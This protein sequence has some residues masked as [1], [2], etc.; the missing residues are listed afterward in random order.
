[1]FGAFATSAVVGG[2]MAL[3]MVAWSGDYIRH[4]VQFQMIMHE[5]LA[6]RDPG[7]LSEQAAARKPTMKLL[8]YG[9][10]LA[11]GSITYFVWTGLLF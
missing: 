8:P 7:K 4:W 1:T 9:I 5:I 2:L 10:P 3:A 6:V 11:V